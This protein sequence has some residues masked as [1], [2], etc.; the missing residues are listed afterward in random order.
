MA[1]TCENSNTPS[2]GASAVS[3]AGLQVGQIMLF[4]SLFSP[5]S[6]LLLLQWQCCFF[7]LLK[8]FL[9][10]D[11]LARNFPSEMW[12][13]HPGV[14]CSDIWL[15]I[16]QGRGAHGSSSPCFSGQPTSPE[17]NRWL[18]AGWNRRIVLAIWHPAPNILVSQSQAVS[19]KP[20][21]FCGQH[22]LVLFF[23]KNL[24]WCIKLDTNAIQLIGLL[25]N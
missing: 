18:P 17:T 15:E 23:I 14:N 20:N 9:Q 12:L 11:L 2:T 13:S 22:H 19:W 25:S 4:Y 3:H 1:L 6:F 10:H 24:A 8:P 21:N 7:Q 5:S 16:W